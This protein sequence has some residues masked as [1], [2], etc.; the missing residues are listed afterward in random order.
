MTE[1]QA[2]VVAYHFSISLTEVLTWDDRV[3]GVLY[4]RATRPIDPDEE[5]F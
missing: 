1:S 2:E 4:R 3:I 5:L